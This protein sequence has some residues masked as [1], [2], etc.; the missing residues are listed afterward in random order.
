MPLGS[1]LPKDDKRLECQMSRHTL[2]MPHENKNKHCG[3]QRAL[4]FFG[5]S[6]SWH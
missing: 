5:F 1:Q 6:R 2:Q 3:E 4:G